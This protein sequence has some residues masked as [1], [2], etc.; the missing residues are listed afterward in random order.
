MSVAA[1]I[2]IPVA[3]FSDKMEKKPFIAL[4]FLFFTLFPVTHYLSKIFLAL[5]FAFTI[6]GLK[7]F[8]EPTRKALITELCPPDAKSSAFGLYYFV[9]DSTVSLAAFR[10]GWLWMKSPGLNLI[11]AA[12]FGILGTVPF[13][14]FGRSP[15]SP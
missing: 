3:N 5:L 11:T 2:Y 12:F 9:R 13:M 7:E 1:L 14:K 15:H 10:G 6:R 4:T 8:G